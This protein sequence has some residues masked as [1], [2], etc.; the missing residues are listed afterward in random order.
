MDQS[1]IDLPS[2]LLRN[3]K[4]WLGASH[5]RIAYSG[6]LD[7]TVL[8][9]L[10]AGLAK[11]ESLPA[12][13]AIHV[14][15]GLQA[16]ADAW[17][18]H[19]QVVC[20]GL[21]VSLQ[22]VRVQVQ[23]GAS[24]ERAARDARYAAFSAAIQANDVLLTGQHRDDQAETLLF[25]LLRGAGVRGLS[26]MPAQRALGQGSL[27]RPLLDVTRAELEVYARD[28][29]LHWVEDPSNQDRQFSRNYLR[30]QVMPLLTG[31]WPQAHASMARSTAHL[32]EAQGLLDELAQID[33]AQATLSDDFEW[34]GLPSLAFAAIAGLSDARQ[35]N[36]LSHWLEPLTRLPDT[37]HWSG[38]L[39]LRDAGNDASPVWRLA[40][41]EL[42]RS[43]G[44]LWWLSGQWL[45]A[46]VVSGD[47]HD[48]SLAL[49][50][51]DNGRVM[52][53]GQTPAGPLRIH[54][55]LG[56]E[57]MHLADRGHRDLKRLLNER[58][59]PGFVRGRLPLLFRGEEL[60]AVANLPGLDGNVQE[61]WQLHWVPFDED[62]GLS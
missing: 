24:L 38:W 34:L 3:L 48:P 45:R 7:S 2:R 60:L 47:W 11:T 9:H 40:D 56:G 55:R 14:H 35:R 23:P 62:Q 4:P 39:D 18:A 32:R 20:D 10:L 5:W 37:D 59:V 57:V 49:R 53:S 51:P 52:F 13:G 28:H 8:L 27:V 15:H 42:H 19:C 1:T 16:A 21:A 54:Y 29:G 17:P 26:G 41:G 46:P 58:A 31:R 50:L 25:R 61:G 44:R 43:T 36:A 30:H 6:G 12:L 33:L 22:V